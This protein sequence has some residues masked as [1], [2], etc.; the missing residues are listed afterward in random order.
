MTRTDE[1]IELIHTQMGRVTEALDDIRINVLPKDPIMYRIMAESYESLLEDLR[2]DLHR[3]EA[4]KAALAAEDP[5][6]VEA[7]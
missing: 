1:S 5:V 2:A 3:Q 6:P 7:N 4:K